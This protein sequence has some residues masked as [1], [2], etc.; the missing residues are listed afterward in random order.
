MISVGDTL[1]MKNPASPNKKHL[2]FVIALTQDGSEA[3]LV[4]MSTR[5]GSSVDLSCILQPGEHRR[6]IDESVIKYLEMIRS[7]VDDLDK[8]LRYFPQYADDRASPAII[9]RIQQG[10]SVSDFARPDYVQIIADWVVANP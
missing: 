6:I 2:F 4:N 8:Y 10:A 3:I 5:D 7:R 9:T 1:W